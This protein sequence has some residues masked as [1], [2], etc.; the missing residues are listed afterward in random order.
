MSS[1]HDCAVIAGNTGPVWEIGHRVSA[2]GA[3]KVLADL[4]EDYACWLAVADATPPILRQVTDLNDA[5]TRFLAWL[6]PA[7]TEG[8]G[9]GAWTVGIEL[10]N[11]A[12]S[13]ELVLELQLTATVTAGVVPA[14]A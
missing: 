1:F 3:R 2:P 10:R 5:G 9:A 13:P 6:T 12:A 4:S 8:L 7:E 11:P 14:A